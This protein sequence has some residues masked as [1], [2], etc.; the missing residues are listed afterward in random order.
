MVDLILNIKDRLKVIADN[1]VNGIAISK[2]CLET[3]I[4]PFIIPVIPNSSEQF[5]MLDPT[6][7]PIPRPNS[8]FLIAVIV[9]ISSG[10]DVPAQTI[11]K[12]IRVSDKPMAFARSVALFTLK[13]APVP[14]ANAEITNINIIIFKEVLLSSLFSDWLIFFEFLKFII[15]NTKNIA[16]SKMHSSV[17]KAPFIHMTETIKHEN[18]YNISVVLIW[19]FVDNFRKINNNPPIMQVLKMADPKAFPTASP[20][21][22]LE[23]E[24]IVTSSSGRV[25]PILVTVAPMTAVGIFAFFAR[26]MEQSTNLSPPQIISANEIMITKMLISILKDTSLNVT[27][28]M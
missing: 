5:I 16:I 2:V 11:V 25:V 13:Y 24:K 12:P 14:I 19:C 4:P 27:Y 18:K 20:L 3:L 23:L 6:M 10:R 7:L 1:S 21:A 15:T 28:Y 9:V 26:E 17:D 8:F 22:S